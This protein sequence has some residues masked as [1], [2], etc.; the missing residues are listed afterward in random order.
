M[1]ILTIAIIKLLVVAAKLTASVTSA[2]DKGAYKIS[3]MFPWIFPIIKEEEEWENDCWITCIAINP[4]AK[5]TI[6][7]K[8]SISDL[9]FPKARDK[10]NKNNKEEINGD[11]SVWIQT[12]K[13]LNTSFL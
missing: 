12:I 5:K 11:K 2:G 6:N 4:G 1:Q 7:G 8:P 9:L 10:T 13:N 3:T